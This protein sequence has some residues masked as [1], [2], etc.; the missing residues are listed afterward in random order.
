MDVDSELQSV[1][2]TRTMAV[3][4]VLAS[5]ALLAACSSSSSTTAT[6]TGSTTSAGTKSADGATVVI[7]NYMYTVPASVRPGQKITVHNEDSVAHTV[8]ADSGSAFDVKVGASASTAFTAPDKSGRYSF[9][10]TYHT[11]MKATL[12]VSS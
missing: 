6:R 8:T 4:V 9:D 7:K 11:Y 10:C 5:A 3:V 1:K 12:V 2:R